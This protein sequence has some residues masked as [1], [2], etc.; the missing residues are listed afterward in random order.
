MLC[1]LI[2]E[3]REESNEKKKGKKK[4]TGKSGLIFIC[5]ILKGAQIGFIPVTVNRDPERTMTISEK[6]QRYDWTARVHSLYCLV[7]YRDECILSVAQG[8]GNTF[9][10]TCCSYQCLRPVWLLYDCYQRSSCTY[11]TS[12]NNRREWHLLSTL[13]DLPVLVFLLRLVT[14]SNGGHTRRENKFLCIHQWALWAKNRWHCVTVLYHCVQGRVSHLCMFKCKCVVLSCG[15]KKLSSSVT[16]MAL[17][18]IYLQ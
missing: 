9:H 18:L 2:R 14:R 17:H 13:W 3:W 1:V 11:F 8:E 5:I 10:S 6:S 15:K 7:D 4:K 16:L 12:T